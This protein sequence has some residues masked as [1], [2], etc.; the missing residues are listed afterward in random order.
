MTENA[1]KAVAS[2]KNHLSFHN[3]QNNL[4]QLIGP[5]LGAQNA[6]KSVGNATKEAFDKTK[7]AGGKGE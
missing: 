1:G 6:A 2:G 5:Y 7:S 4:I 3:Y